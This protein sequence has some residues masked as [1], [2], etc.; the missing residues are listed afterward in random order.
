[1]NGSNSY[2]GRGLPCF[3]FVVCKSVQRKH[4]GSRFRRIFQLLSNFFY[5]VAVSR[6]RYAGRYCRSRL[7]LQGVISDQSLVMVMNRTPFTAAPIS[8]QA[9]TSVDPVVIDETRVLQPRPACSPG[10]HA[11][12]VHLPPCPNLFITCFCC[13]LVE[14][15]STI[16]FVKDP[17]IALRSRFFAGVNNSRICVSYTFA[18]SSSTNCTMCR[19]IAAKNRFEIA[20]TSGAAIWCAYIM[21]GT[22]PRRGIMVAYV[23]V[24]ISVVCPSKHFGGVCYIQKAVCT[25]T[26][27]DLAQQSDNCLRAFRDILSVFSVC[28]SGHASLRRMLV[29]PNSST[30]SNEASCLHKIQSNAA[31]GSSATATTCKP[32][33][34]RRRMNESDD[35]VQ[36]NPEQLRCLSVGLYVPCI[37]CKY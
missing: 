6:T 15:T 36:P 29:P 31:Q 8:R 5:N 23:R 7:H 26:Y 1:M 34:S 32:K 20:R 12:G 10:V 9:P 33:D 11:R 25:A 30:P 35:V 13:Y 19:H 14:E 22:G 21:E 18:S 2:R 37:S 4:C 24:K 28:E 3:V 16:S 27:E 17:G